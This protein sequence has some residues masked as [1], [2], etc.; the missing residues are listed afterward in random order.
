MTETHDEAS[1]R[2]AS[3]FIR[4]IIDADLR[5]GRHR[6]VV[7]RFP[8][9][10]NGYLHIGHAKSIVLN[11]GLAQDYGG[12]CNLRFDDTNPET[13][14]EEYASSIRESVRWL[15]FD[16]GDNL[17]YASDYFE[18][19]YNYAVKLIQ[20]GLAYVDS[21]TDEQIRASRG[22]VTEPGRESPYRDRTVAENL[23]MFAA[24]RAGEY[25]DGA[26][27]LRGRINMA[28][29]NMKMRDPLL[30]RI[31]HAHHYRSGNDWCIYPMY[32]FA[33]PLEDAI[34]GITHSLCT[35]EF[36]NNRELYDWVLENCLEPEQMESRPRQYEFSRLNVEYTVMSKRKLLALVRQDLVR[37][38]DD[39]RMPTLAGMRRRGVTPDAIRSFCDQVGV[40]K[41]ESRTDISLFEHTLRDS[42]NH[43]APRVMAVVRPLKV[44][45]TNYPEGEI[46]ELE[47]PYW[48]HDVPRE[49]SRTIYFSRELFI[50]QDDFMEEPPRD[51]FRLSPGVEVRL[52]YGYLIRC[53]R[54]VRDESGAI[55][56]VQ[57]TYDPAT[58]GGDAPDSRKVRGTI[59]WVSASK[60]VAAEIRLY[61]RLFS[62][63]DPEAGD[64]P[65]TDHLNPTSLIVEH[66]MVEPSVLE[67]PPETRY[68][69]ERQG[70]FWRDP[71]DCSDALLVFNRIV[72]LRD[73]WSKR[74][75]VQPVKAASPSP[76]PRPERAAAQSERTDPVD[77]LDAAGRQR[78]DDLTV[79]FS[80]N[81]DDAALIAADEHLS[82][83]FRRA[84]ADSKL[85]QPLANWLVHEVRREMNARGLETIPI[86]PNDF[87]DLVRLVSSNVI[88]SS[89]GQT[90][91][92]RMFQDGRSPESIVEEEGLRQVNEV[93]TLEPEVDE[94]LSK[95]PDRVEAYRS[96][97][98]GLLGFFTGQVMRRT[99]GRAN[100][101]VIKEL[102][103]E[104]L[105]G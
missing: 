59:H 89:A 10:P 20:K 22:T 85:Y 29:V 55:I 50:E 105:G 21:Q 49:G 103:E 91:L 86:E 32:D 81:R 7:T 35:L 53:E 51:F 80:I 104:K 6:Q 37:G 98:K 25:P 78:F 70:Y 34:E 5:S 74:R 41:V 101:Q 97:K 90:V 54:V 40:T 69:F 45:I 31:K 18:R 99:E 65:F 1:A 3:N 100:P 61:D 71:V 62:R 95:F 8:P 23:E 64:D 63:P 88:N 46:E 15:G 60:A 26:H 19:F 66:G 84:A 43:V 58:R 77:L 67:D 30:Y 13:E 2:G 92:A 44:V 102:L 52:R 33:H 82:A 47:A 4:D 17:F 27:V 38:W 83:F 57:C 96:G 76:A 87:A 16:W 9:E 48:P 72:S 24:M 68:Q 94:V 42:L 79:D 36:D 73:S 11:F 14:S 39:P 12:Q 75:K 28:A 93:A 56:E